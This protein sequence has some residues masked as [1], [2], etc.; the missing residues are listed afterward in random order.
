MVVVISVFSPAV[1]GANF[2]NHAID[3]A[4]RLRDTGY[5]G[6]QPVKSPFDRVLWPRVDHRRR[7]LSIGF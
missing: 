7:D 3:A 2:F 4:G 6:G 5:V 1:A